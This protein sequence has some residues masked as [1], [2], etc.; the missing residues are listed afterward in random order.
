MMRAI[1]LDCG[2]YPARPWAHGN[3]GWMPSFVGT[4]FPTA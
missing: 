4:P 2:T 1:G 3:A